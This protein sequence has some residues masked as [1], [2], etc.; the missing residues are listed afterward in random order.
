M[1]F[2]LPV[3]VSMTFFFRHQLRSFSLKIVDRHVFFCHPDS[4]FQLSG[5]FPITVF[6][7]SFPFNEVPS[8]SLTFPV[9]KMF[10]NPP[11]SIYKLIPFPLC[12]SFLSF[13]WLCVFLCL[14]E[15]TFPFCDYIGVLFFLPLWWKTDFF[16]APFFL[17][18]IGTTSPPLF[19]FRPTR[20]RVLVS[21][22]NLSHIYYHILTK[23]R[24]FSF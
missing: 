15:G 12:A 4:P 11:H 20:D 17:V 14:L 16:P 8:K 23:N 19:H 24:S 2:L 9:E 7:F 10:L 6:L 13:L 18:L 21:P 22:H 3:R 5:F 1:N